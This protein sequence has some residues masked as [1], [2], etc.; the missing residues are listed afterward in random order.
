MT[1]I[2][3]EMFA[4][5]FAVLQDLFGDI[6]SVQK[7][8]R[9]LASI[10]LS[11]EPKAGLGR[12]WA[13]IVGCAC[14]S[15]EHHDKLVDILVQLSKLPSPKTAGGDALILYDMQIWKDLPTLGWALREQWN[16]SVPSGPPDNRQSVISKI[17]NRDKFTALL[18]ATEEPVFAYSWFAIFTLRDALEI[19]INQLLPTYPLEALIPAAAWISTLGVEIYEWD[20][21]L[22]GYKG[23]A[24]GSGGPLCFCKERWQLWRKR[25]GEVARMRGEIGDEARTAARE[26]EE[27]M[28]EIENGEVE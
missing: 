1:A 27:M 13:V 3:D 16:I 23:M 12:L 20:K 11:I 8:V 22:S 18:M 21:D 5:Q 9:D 4:P 25:F 19:P 14:E 7:A 24:P 28:L 6:I 15:P 2:T 26:A 17:I 10:S